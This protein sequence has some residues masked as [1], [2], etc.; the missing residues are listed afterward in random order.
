MTQLKS[1]KDD[2]ERKLQEAGEIIGQQER[3][4]IHQNIIIANLTNKTRQLESQNSDLAK[5]I[6]EKTIEIE[7]KKSTIEKLQQ[8]VTDITAEK[9]TVSK[10]FQGL[11]QDKHNF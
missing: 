1:E 2:L 8:H 3:T 4:I 11:D 5:I 6:D 10:L 7:K 9:D